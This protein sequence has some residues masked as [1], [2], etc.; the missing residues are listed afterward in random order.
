ML[1]IYN[2]LKRIMM[3]IFA[4]MFL[5]ELVMEVEMEALD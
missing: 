2:I 1:L 5:W 4:L 3:I